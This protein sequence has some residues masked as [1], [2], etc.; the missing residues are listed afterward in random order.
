MEQKRALVTGVTGQDG[1]YLAKFLL[2]KGYKVFGTYRRVSTPN[3]WRLQEL[4]I[5]NNI[6][7]IPADLSD[8]SSLVEA[9]S[10]SNPDEIYNLAAQSFVGGSFDQP[11]LTNDIDATGTLRFLEIIRHSGKPI[12]FYQASPA[13]LVPWMQQR[14]NSTYS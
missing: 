10:I 4:G 9:V 5:I 3:F 13:Y 12:K 8:M 14:S 2:E 6:T 1:P 7:M 11:I